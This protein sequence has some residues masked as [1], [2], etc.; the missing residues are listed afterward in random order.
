MKTTIFCATALLTLS[1]IGQN[2]KSSAKH[3]ITPAEHLAFQRGEVLEYRVHYGFV[4]AGNARMEVS[5]SADEVNGRTAYKFVGT[6]KSNK[7]F[8]MFFKV[9]DYYVSYMDEENLTPLKFVRRVDEGGYK[10]KQDYIFHPDSNKVD[11][12]KGQIVDVPIDVQDMISAF[13]YARNLDMTGAQIGDI[14]GLP[15]FLDD[16]IWELQMK[17]LGTETL[18]ADLGKFDC[19]KFAPVVQKGRIFKDEEDL[20]VYITND[21]N[22]IPV[23]A[24]ANILVG[25]IK[26]D[27][28]SYGGLAHPIAKLK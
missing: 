10:I 5:M 9:R 23:Q 27:L 28:T 6:G 1:T 14:F 17:Y 3:Q 20:V 21:K 24:K 4:D 26:M 18:K 8:D 2:P 11:N 16:E 13:Y 15:C 19:L 25:S 7:F 12:G 22:R